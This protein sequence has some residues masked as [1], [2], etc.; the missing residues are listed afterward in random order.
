VR[1]RALSIEEV[2]VAGKI[3][4]IEIPCEDVDRGQRFWRGLF[5]WSFGQSVMPDMEYRMADL[6]NG[7]GAA[8]Y[9][10]ETGHPSYYY[11]TDDIEATIAKVKELGGQADDKMPVPTHGWFAACKDSEGNAFHLWQNDPN[12]A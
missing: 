3:V 5:G 9:Q 10:A 11:D 1:L 6:G 4:H 12:A 7:V 2:E 8:V